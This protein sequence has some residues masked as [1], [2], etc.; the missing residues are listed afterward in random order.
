MTTPTHRFKVKTYGSPVF[1]DVCHKIL[2]GLV[3]QG[4]CCQ[5]CGFDAHFKCV[6]D[7]G[8]CPGERRAKSHHGKDKR[9]QDTAV[10]A[11]G[12]VTSDG[13]HDD[14]YHDG[15]T[16][17]DDAT[18]STVA[19]PLAPIAADGDH[20]LPA[21]ANMVA[22]LD[23]ASGSDAV[24]RPVTTD[25]DSG[26][27]SAV[28]PM[29]LTVVPNDSGILAGP[30][31][32]VVPAAPS[33]ARKSLAIDIPGRSSRSKKS[34]TRSRSG[35]TISATSGTTPTSSTT[36]SKSRNWTAVMSS[37]I[38]STSRHAARQ[39]DEPR[40]TS[41]NL[42]TTTPKN[43]NRFI[44]RI[45][46][47]H[48][49]ERGFLDLI[50]WRNKT[51]TM[52][53]MAVY[54]L[55]CLYPMALVVAP[56]VLLLYHLS[57][58]YYEHTKARAMAELRTG[59]SQPRSSPAPRIN[60]DPA[61]S[62]STADFKDNMKFVQN[63]MAQ[64][65]D[66]YDTIV[67]FSRQYLS[68][69]QPETTGTLFKIV[70]TS[71]VP[72][73]VLFYYVPL[74]HLALLAG[75]G[76][77]VA[78]TPFVLAVRETVLPVVSETLSE[79]WAFAKGVVKQ[80]PEV[81]KIKPKAVS[82]K[83]NA[84]DAASVTGSTSTPSIPE[85]GLYAVAIYEN[86]RW[87]LGLA[88]VPFLLSHERPPWSD[89]SGTIPLPPKATY[90]P[91]PGFEWVDTDWHIDRNWSVVAPDAE[92]WVHSDHLWGNPR[93]NPGMGAL[94][95]RR[96]WVRRV[97]RRV[98][99]ADAAAALAFAA[100]EL[101]MS[102]TVTDSPASA[103]VA[104]QAVTEGAGASS[105]APARA[106]SGSASSASSTTLFQRD[107]ADTPLA[108]GPRVHVGG[109]HRDVASMMVRP[110]DLDAVILADQPAPLAPPT[111]PA[112]PPAEPP[113]TPPAEVEYILDLDG[114]EIVLEGVQSLDLIDMDRLRDVVRQL[115][116]QQASKNAGA[117]RR[118]RVE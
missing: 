35:S 43:F 30:E 110:T 77:F 105:A 39:E 70:A 53:A 2:W 5:K 103:T 13:E 117:V 107:N 73:F 19:R 106:R 111:M 86:Q 27:D 89:Y 82:R 42:L 14:G 96:K 31:S 90:T 109:A 94:T 3:R 48:S 36:P 47:I 79:N 98:D 34:K 40:E 49:L 1:C 118:V 24:V 60:A 64:Y 66:V 65:S 21:S 108:R 83:T 4:V 75:W 38:T 32:A 25:S 88:Y 6:D 63:I 23:D 93:T 76:V 8:P 55:V 33:N 9:N 10:P 18:M 57:L 97:A 87:W 11:A 59:K 112:E 68:W 54:T 37:L 62:L 50:K 12:A 102:P 115:K 81:M 113:A 26:H 85:E 56:Q 7:A 52:L 29:Q 116:A 44:S 45:G 67:L 72:S 69:D 15:I 28:K 99:A 80:W 95:R 74:Q 101:P 84:T 16:S 17:G 104:P 61:P 22:D 51:L 46:P 91:P 41:L 20:L 58:G 71:I 114:E 92:G 100:Q 78:Q